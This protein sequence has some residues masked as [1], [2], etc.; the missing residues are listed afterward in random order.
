MS[1]ESAPKLKRMVIGVS[2][3]KDQ[4]RTLED[5]FRQYP[6]AS[7]GKIILALLHVATPMSIGNALNK[8]H[9][10]KLRKGAGNEK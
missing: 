6:G 5:L 1:A 4:E 2:V 8:H 10:H 7:P 9:A 3:P